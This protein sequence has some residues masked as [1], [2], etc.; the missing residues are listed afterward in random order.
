[1]K[2]EVGRFLYNLVRF[3]FEYFCDSQRILA[4]FAK[5]SLIAFRNMIILLPKSQTCHP[6][7]AQERFI[8]HTCL[9]DMTKLYKP[10]PLFTVFLAHMRL[11]NLCT[12]TTCPK[13]IPEI[14]LA[15]FCDENWE[16]GKDFIK[17]CHV[18][19]H[20]WEME[21]SVSVR[22][23]SYLGKGLRMSLALQCYNG[24][25]SSNFPCKVTLHM[26]TGDKG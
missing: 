14:I 1:M 11:P 26:T 22:W 3:V 20:V 5:F 6:E 23:M 24:L 13:L 2:H 18:K 17:I 9:P 15:R 21:G 25:K 8:S 7:C 16:K 12:K 10:L 4:S 19:K